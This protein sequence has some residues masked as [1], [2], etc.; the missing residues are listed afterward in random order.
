MTDEMGMWLDQQVENQRHDAQALK[1]LAT[2]MP[3]PETVE[4][5]TGIADTLAA[6]ADS[7]RRILDVHRGDDREDCAGCGLDAIGLPVWRIDQC[8]TRLALALAYADKPGYSEEW[9]S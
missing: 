3:A 7:K 5:L 8:P 2:A 1:A 6:D 9:Q 4:W